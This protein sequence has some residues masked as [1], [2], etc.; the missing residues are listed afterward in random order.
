MA[1]TRTQLHHHRGRRLTAAVAAAAALALTAGPGPSQAATGAAKGD[2]GGRTHIVWSRFV[3]TDFS[4]AAIV[5]RAVGRA[6]AGRGPVR[7]LTHPAPGETDIDPRI[8]PNGRWV[9]FERDIA[10]SAHVGLVRADGTGEH[11]LRSLCVDPCVAAIAPTW[12]PDGRHLLFTRVNGPFDANGNAASAVLMKTDLTG[13]HVERFSQRGIEPRLEDYNATFAPA[14]YVVFIRIRNATRPGEAFHSAAF[15][16][17]PNGTN[18]R[19]LTPW[20]LDA[21]TLEVSP[22]THGPSEDLVVFETFGHGPPEG[23]SSAVGTVPATCRTVSVCRT[24]I[25][26]LTPDDV[27]PQQN[28]NPAWSPDGSRIAFVRFSATE[29]EVTGDIWTMRWNGADK[30]PFATAPVFEFRPSWGRLRR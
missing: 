2:G 30:R 10:D 25:R 1:S 7:V 27:L 17:R 9:A 28:F 3:D 15:R 23:V 4:A 29:E 21:D 26:M 16:M 6:A 8:S 22:A 18:V 24:K 20:R 5:S 14:G 12:T 13:D 11:L 19:R